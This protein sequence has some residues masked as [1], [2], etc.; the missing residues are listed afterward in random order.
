MT[1]FLVDRV[2]RVFSVYGF[3]L[4]DLIFHFLFGCSKFR[5]VGREARNL[6]LIGQV[7]LDSVRQYEV[8]VSQTLHQCRCT[9][10]VSTVV[11]EVGF[12]DS[13]QTRDRS[14]QF[15][16]NP[17]TTHG[18]VDSGEYHHRSLVRVLVS[19]FFVHVEEVTITGTNHVLTQTIDSI[20]E[21]EEDGQ[22]GIVH[23]ETG[24]TTF[25]GCT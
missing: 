11:G 4:L 9:Q 10:A 16:I 15:I 5:Q 25:F 6:N 23:T 3:D 18:V 22:T 19:D 20:F 13:E 24:I 21:I 7:V 14:H 2:N 1:Q 17:D 12:T 8:S